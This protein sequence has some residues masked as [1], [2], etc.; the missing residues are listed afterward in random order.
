MDGLGECEVGL[1]LVR[2]QWDVSRVALR[3]VVTMLVV[4][5]K[6]ARSVMLLETS[7]LN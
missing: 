6:A 4:H 3:T 2:R 1:F 7:Y 5:G